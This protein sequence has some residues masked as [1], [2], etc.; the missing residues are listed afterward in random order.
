MSILPLSEKQDDMEQPEFV[1]GSGEAAAVTVA[2]LYRA[3]MTSLARAVGSTGIHPN[4]LTF[5]SFLPSIAAGYAASQGALVDAALL[6]LFGGIF[7]L[8]DGAVAR[9]MGKT[10]TFGALLDST[11]DRL[12]DAAIPAGLA[13]Y[14]APHGAIAIIPILAL[15]AGFIVS[16]IRA[17]AEGL[18]LELPRLW[19]R[20]EDRLALMVLALFL[21]PVHVPGLTITGGLTMV[22][23]GVLALAS[24]AS[25]A[26]ALAV[27]ARLAP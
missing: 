17:R 4:L 18:K 11:L 6:F 25:A 19:M 1:D 24:F 21:A 20:R 12:S 7:D 26:M 13:I 22:V 8:L 14:Y 27:A 9:E 23:L 5:I 15:I 10:S 16:Y 2:G 3:I